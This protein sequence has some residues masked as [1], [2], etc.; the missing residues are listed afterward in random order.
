MGMAYAFPITVWC[1][2]AVL[3]GFIFF[4]SLG[5]ANPA[6]GNNFKEGVSSTMLFKRVMPILFFIAFCFL[7]LT[8]IEAK[9]TGDM[10]NLE[11]KIV[12]LD[13]GHGGLDHG[14]CKKNGVCERDIT[15]EIAQKTALLLKK[16]G[17]EVVMT[18]KNKYSRWF[19]WM[20]RE[21]EISLD[22]RIELAK[23]KKADIF[24]SLHCNASPKPHRTGAVVFYQDNSPAS[25][26]LGDHIQRELVKI[27]E[28]GKRTDKPCSYYLL[29]NLPVPAVVI[30]TCYLTHRA[31]KENI[32]NVKYRE[33]IAAAVFSG[34]TNYLSN[35]KSAGKNT[36]SLKAGNSLQQ[37]TCETVRDHTS[38]PAM[39]LA[40]NERLTAQVKD[41]LAI[42]FTSSI[43]MPG[44]MEIGNIEVSGSQ[45]I[46]DMKTARM[47]YSLGGEEEYNVVYAI[48]NNAL[49]IPGIQNV[50][51]TLNGKPAE[52]LAGHIDISLP[53]ARTSPIFSRIPF[54]TK[55]GKKAQVAIVIDDFGQ[56][57]TD[58]VKEI[59]NLD[60]PVT[61]AVMP[62]LDN[63]R[64]HAEEA[65]KL[66]YEII[67][68]LPL[69]PVR[70]KRNWLG[71]GAI[72]TNM[73]EE[74][75]KLV[76]KKDFDDVP[77]AVG[78]NNHMGSAVT[79]NEK[80]MRPI[81]QAAKEKEFFVLDSKTTAK[82]KMPAL[83]DEMEIAYLERNVFLDDVKSLEHVKKQLLKL[84][85]EALVRGKAIGIGHVGKG[86]KITA[87]AIEE[88]IPRM[89]EMGIEFVYLSEMA[90]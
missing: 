15:M 26:S 86:G 46:I 14:Y 77:Y 65:A 60:I 85:Q 59:F 37:G 36:T 45:A 81:M 43:A 2:L 31:D 41:N 19:P 57:N 47:E 69:E 22:E 11:G 28:N 56:Y 88:M 1:P 76:A 82:S 55:E 30:E 24:I 34:I 39:L 84:S 40:D 12:L 35:Q 58:G 83:S 74:E 32:L 70:G 8:A 20:G 4:T 42:N 38:S 6:V 61:C 63:T 54:G 62:N 64:S 67:A 78:F 17:A 80:I 21:S 33:K 10:N 48:V 7:F 71:P 89:Q 27:P 52:T 25:N 3:S 23:S 87:R 51:L 50:L 90:Y 53:I 75:I 44:D 18:H 29:N 5:D 9:E 13:P 72:T 66:G 49:K 73:L 16:N 79:A 68:H